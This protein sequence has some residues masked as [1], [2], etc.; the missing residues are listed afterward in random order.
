M[1]AKAKSGQKF[2]LMML[3]VGLAAGV[4]MTLYAEKELYGPKAFDRLAAQAGGRAYLTALTVWQCVIYAVVCGFFGRIMAE[5]LGL[6]N[7]VKIKARGAKPALILG[8]GLG[9]TLVA[10]DPLIFSKF[11]PALSPDF[12]SPPTLLNLLCSL[13]YGGIIE[14][15]MMRLFVMSL[16]SLI[17]WKL[18]FRRN[19]NVPAGV[20]AAANIISALLFAA[21]HLPVTAQTLGITPVILIRC[22][23]INGRGGLA[24]GLLY[25]KHGIQYSML[26]HRTAH[27]VRIG[28]CYI[29]AMLN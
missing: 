18:F 27:M 1:K 4:I 14:E 5:S 15:L 24:F 6:W 20:L 22:F 12:T 29:L 9:V 25:R 17:I 2:A 3:P 19:E 8:R 10:A 26:C 28:L 13:L 23:V 11:V 7:G 16:V 21:G